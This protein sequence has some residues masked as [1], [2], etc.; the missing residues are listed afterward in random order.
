VRFLQNWWNVRFGRKSWWHP[1]FASAHYSGNPA[2]LISSNP[3]PNASLP[4]GLLLKTVI[5]SSKGL[6]S[7]FGK[8]VHAF[9][10]GFGSIN[11]MRG[12]DDG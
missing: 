12:G 10:A 9:L 11:G 1:V 6:P 8:S 2:P 7:G 4:A 3:A 5:L